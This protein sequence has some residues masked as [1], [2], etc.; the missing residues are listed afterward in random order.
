M[1]EQ[2]PLSLGLGLGLGLHSLLTQVLVEE[3]QEWEKN[4]HA[5]AHL[6]RGEPSLRAA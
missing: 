3:L 1:L 4:C 2:L 6:D 5:G